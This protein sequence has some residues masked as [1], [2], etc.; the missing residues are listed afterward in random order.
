[1]LAWDICSEELMLGIKQIKVCRLS[2]ICFVWI[3]QNFKHA[4][5]DYWTSVLQ[6]ILFMNFFPTWLLF[7]VTYLVPLKSL[8]I[9]IKISVNFVLLFLLQA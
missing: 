7:C 5:L 6:E 4:E 2:G 9:Y 3:L 1:M 8:P